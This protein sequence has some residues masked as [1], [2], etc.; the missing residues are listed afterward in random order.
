[1][2]LRP[3]PIEAFASLPRVDD[4]NERRASWRQ[5]FT[6]LGQQPRI[7]GPPALDQVDVGVVQQACRTALS[8]GLADDL[9]WIGGEQA[10]VA[11]YELTTALPPGDERREFG[12]RVFQR[13]FGGPAG[14]FVA[15]AQ[16]MAWSGVKQLESAALRARVG[17]C[18]TLPVGSSVNVD[19]LALALVSGSQRF[20]AWVGQPSTG[21]LPKRRLSARI[22]ERASREAVR[23]SLA[24]DPQPLTWLLGPEVRPVLDRL[25]ADREP[26]VWRHAA[27]A[28]GT[29]AEVNPSL[30]EE[31]DL[32]LDP[33][34]SPAQWRRAAVSLMACLSHDADTALPQC[35][36]LFSGEIARQHPGL[37]SAALW[38]L[39]PVIE[40]EPELAEEAVAL[41]AATGR[42]DVAD[43][44]ALLR[45]Q[46]ANPDFAADAAK[47]LA[48][49]LER[50]QSNVDPALRALTR[51]CR[52][53]L[54]GDAKATQL[55]DEL[56][57]ASLAYENDDALRA[58]NLAASALEQAHKLM[59]QIE[60]A[61][62]ES[63]AGLLEVYPELA[64]LGVSLLEDS[65]LHDLLL[66][67]RKP[68]DLSA[69]VP[70]YDNLLDRL[71]NWLLRSEQLAQ[72]E[73]RP[74]SASE[75][76][77]RRSKLVIFLHL[78]DTQ[79]VERQEDGKTVRQRL[80]ASMM[81]L[82]TNIVEGP[83][84]TLHR[85]MCAALARSFDAAVRESMIEPSD[86]L[87]VVMSRLDEHNSLN[88]IME[89]STEIDMRRCLH[90]Y[91]QLLAAVRGDEESDDET[92]VWRDQRVA[93]A[94][95]QFS[96]ELAAR[97]SYRGEALRQSLLRLG[98]AMEA[99]VAARALS[100]FVPDESGQRNWL[101]EL[102][103]ATDGLQLL[104]QGASARVRGIRLR[105]QQRSVAVRSGQ[106]L[107]SM[108]ERCVSAATTLP[109][110]DLDTALVRMVAGLPQALAEPITQLCSRLV[111]LPHQ[112]AREVAVI[113]LK[114]RRTALP[115]W[116]LPR[117]TIGGFYV[118][119]ALGTG[120]VSTV[121]VAK[122]I[123]ERKDPDAE[124][125][126]LKIPHYDP[127]TARSLSEQEFLDMFRDEAGALLS[128]PRHENLSGFVN[129]DVAAKPKP[130]LV[131]ELIAG[132]SLERLLLRRSLAAETVFRY[133][134]GLLSGLIAM[135]RAGVAH[136]DIKPSN[137]IVR[138]E[139]TPVL[140]D[141]GLSGR[142]L[143]PG[144]GTLEYCAPEVLGVIPDGA[145]P[146]PTRAD[147][148]AFACMAFEL[149]TGRL[150]FD[151]DDEAALMSQQL[152]HDGWPDALAQLAEIDGMRPI[153]AVLGAC[154]RRDFRHRPS[155]PK[156]AQRCTRRGRSSTLGTCR[157]PW[158]AQS[159]QRG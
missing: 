91:G 84:A 41:L 13:T 128:L 151:A 120:G 98:R 18:F 27:V 148:Y 21:P 105:T 26:L 134:D 121:F 122:R 30:R 59:T 3:N 93:R 107:S 132:Q 70:Q 20:A 68:G 73:S 35:R 69:V 36:N 88:A 25:L 79:S 158:T 55:S 22:L 87:L 14:P 100:E 101:E 97:G 77:L 52:A 81:T 139:S 110:T 2:R 78:L 115:D 106:P 155:A 112:L 92:S 40:A 104:I 94:V 5:A 86:L 138:D 135:H 42:A 153:A 39:P 144:C 66:L 74:W 72:A 24:G 47:Q 85:V 102:E 142:Q 89:G 150:L 137:V 111:S 67:G 154:L 145:T 31:I 9:D 133:M 126:A 82:L 17:L 125:Y 10:I 149:L 127:T 130:I 57:A 56:R 8:H 63:P 76:L 34:L 50:Q 15:V 147:V 109:K 90:A 119:R 49:T 152:S 64:D 33:E 113:P 43:E 6:F 4:P 51:R 117:R 131:M 143:R 146:D 32:Q 11:L 114:K 156:C 159:K 54:V 7:D 95:I 71:G 65:R 60:T 1:M 75:G 80:R 83:D 58:C 140:V 61:S 96:S 116:L 108:V 23:R 48:A 157:G 118:V 141:F 46:V 103:T 38:G 45:R 99:I 12:K 62:A 29:L 124:T 53:M 44:L 28:R 19:P 129:F 123:E 136:L 37:L 16:R